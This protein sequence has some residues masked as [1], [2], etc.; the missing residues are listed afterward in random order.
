[1]PVKKW[2]WL[3][4]KEFE[5]TKRATEMALDRAWID[6]ATEKK[7]TAKT[8]SKEPSRTPALRKAAPDLWKKPSIDAGRSMPRP[9][10]AVPRLRWSAAGR[11]IAR[12]QAEMQRQDAGL[13]PG[14]TKIARQKHW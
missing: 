1:M 6:I 8:E 13:K 4:R 2:R 11:D 10:E 9:Y 3:A 14:A 12:W 5:R 7:A